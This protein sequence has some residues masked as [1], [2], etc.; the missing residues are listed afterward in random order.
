MFQEEYWSI[1]CRLEFCLPP[2][3]VK[4]FFKNKKVSPHHERAVSYGLSSTL[5]TRLADLEMQKSKRLFN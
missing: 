2:Y 5:F 1:Y 3:F 4:R